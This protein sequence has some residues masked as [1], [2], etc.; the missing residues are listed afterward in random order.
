MLLSY[1]TFLTAATAAALLLMGGC[2]EPP[3][4]Q[5]ARKA[6]MTPDPPV[7][8]RQAFQ[9]MYISA[10]GWA[11]DV[12]PLLVQ[13][14][15]LTQV[16]GEKGKAGAWQATFVSPSLGRQRLYSWS[17][18]EAEGS[19]HKGVFSGSEGSWSPGGQRPFLLAALKVDSDQA[20]ETALKQKET[21]E[22]LKKTP[23]IPLLFILEQNRR[24]PDLS[25]RVVFGESVSTSAY[26]VFVDASTGDFLQKTH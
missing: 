13:S 15:N 24:F 10:R 2:G 9:Q 6:E 4:K 25:W 3:A 1:R 18:V 22:L 23:D 7:T 12:Q 21:M 11:P 8:G 19:L 5:A 14:Y 20:Y 17:A 26:S 16:K